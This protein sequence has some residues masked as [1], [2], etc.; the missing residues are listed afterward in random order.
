VKAVLDSQ[1]DRGATKD[2]PVPNI[3]NSHLLSKLTMEEGLIRR[4]VNRLRTIVE[5]KNGDTYNEGG[6][7]SHLPK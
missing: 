1:V 4:E 5:S 3:T 2:Y 7:Y 6:K